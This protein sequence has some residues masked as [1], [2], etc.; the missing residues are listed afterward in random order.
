MKPREELTPQA[1]DSS[2][3]VPARRR[4]G[5][6]AL[7]AL[8]V[9]AA[10]GLAGG[11]VAPVPYGRGRGGYGDGG[12]GGGYP[13]APVQGPVVEVAPP[14]PQYEVIPVAPAVGW[15]WI[16]GH[17]T[18]HLGRHVWVGGRWAAP[19]PGHVW[20]GPRWE[21]VHPRGWRYH[22]GYWRRH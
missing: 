10:G 3:A 16:G 5:R 9:L 11:V 13:Q 12:P 19:L 1:I 8:G 4:F 15:I 20:V 14:P 17:W 7:L 21:S 22:G 18:W 2:D 6:S